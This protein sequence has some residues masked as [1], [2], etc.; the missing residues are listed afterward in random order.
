MKTLKYYFWLIVYYLEIAFSKEY[1]QIKN[2]R[3]YAL[4]LHHSVRQSYDG[5]PY[6]FHLKKVENNVKRFSYL[7]EGD[8]DANIVALLHDSIEDCRKTYNDIKEDY[9]KNIADGVYACT[10]LRGKN[11]SERHGSD[12]YELLKFNRIGRFVKICDVIANMERGIETGSG[13]LA[14]YRKEYDHF[15]DE[16]YTDEFSQMFKYIETNL[17]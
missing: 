12:Y 8:M 3:K 14:R 1:Y 16:L 9:D 17:L 11:R 15:K 13:M 10:E 7:I 4:L 6:Y 5:Y 2:A